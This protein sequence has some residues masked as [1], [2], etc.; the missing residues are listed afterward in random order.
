MDKDSTID[1]PQPSNLGAAMKYFPYQLIAAANDWIDQSS[2][3]QAK[4]EIRFWKAVQKYH[5]ELDRLKPRIGQRAWQFFR[6]GFGPTGLHDGRL[7]S[8][9]IGDGL[10]FAVD[11]TKPF[12]LNHQRLAV[13]LE[14]LNY[15]QD[16]HYVFDLRGVGSIQ[17]DLFLDDCG[18]GAGDLYTYEILA[19]DD[20]NLQLAFLFA[21]GAAVVV[22]FRK[23]VFRRRGIHRR[24]EVGEMYS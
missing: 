4:A 12:R 14:F 23:L 11:G 21:S 1:P 19:I 5:R 17:S 16:L 9:R 10:D 20:D 2:A 22:Q 6:H 13:R 24:Y 15:E 3:D 7:L 18:K 8:M